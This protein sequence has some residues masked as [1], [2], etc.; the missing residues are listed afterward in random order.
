MRFLIL[1]LLLSGPLSL[2]DVHKQFSAG[3]SLFYTASFGSIQRAL[4]QLL[5]E[6]SVTVSPAA[7]GRRNRKVHSVTA[8]GRAAWHA[9]MLAPLEEGAAETTMLAKVFLLGRLPQGSSRRVVLESIS[10]RTVRDYHQ[11]QSLGAALDR[12]NKNTELSATDRDEFA[13]QRATLSYG[14]RSHELALTWLGELVEEE[15]LTEVEGS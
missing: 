9:W 5:S 8:A 3:I 7:D 4:T 11:L 15:D 14:L 2:Y 13:Y 12:Q 6:G 1:G 10:E